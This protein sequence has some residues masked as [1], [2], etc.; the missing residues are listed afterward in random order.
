MASLITAVGV[1]IAAIKKLLDRILLPVVTKIDRMDERQ[2]KVF[3]I[4]FLNDIE[5]GMHKD[6]VQYKFAHEVY[7]HYRND[8]HA[9]SYVHDKWQRIMNG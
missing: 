8:L 4:D 3:L 2:C 6:E 9:N 7:D 1:I 5:N